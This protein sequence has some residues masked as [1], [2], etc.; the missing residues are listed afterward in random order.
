MYFVLERT[1]TIFNLFQQK[2]GLI[3]LE[4]LQ[5]NVRIW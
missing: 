5:K 3:P 4:L 2:E 1:A